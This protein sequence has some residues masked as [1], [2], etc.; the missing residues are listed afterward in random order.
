MF[1]C[2][3][4]AEDDL[5]R[6]DLEKHLSQV[7]RPFKEN[8]TRYQLLIRS[9]QSRVCLA[10]H[11]SKTQR[12]TS[13]LFSTVCEVVM[14]GKPW[15]EKQTGA[16]TQSLFGCLNNFC[17]YSS[18]RAWLIIWRDTTTRSTSV[19]RTRSVQVCL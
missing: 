6:I 13:F 10:A 5:A 14:D 17:F 4:Q 7:D 1:F 11:A 19:S 8:V 2:L 15:L 18:D 16:Q 9:S 3:S 12:L